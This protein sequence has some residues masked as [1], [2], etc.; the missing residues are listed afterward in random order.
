MAYSLVTYTSSGGQTYNVPFPYLEQAH[1]KVY[2]NGVATSAF[3]WSDAATIHL[4]N[5]PAVGA[6]VLIKRETPR[7]GMDKDFSAQP[8]L[9]G[10]DLDEALLQAYYIGLEALDNASHDVLQAYVDDAAAAQVAAEL[11][12]TNAEAARDLAIGAKDAAILARG[13]AEAARD[14]AVLAKI[15]AESYAESAGAGTYQEISSAPTTDANEV[16][17]YAKDVTGV[18]ELFIRKESNGTEVQVTN[19]AGLSGAGAH[20]ASH[21]AGGADSIKLDEL[22]APTDVTTLN[23]SVSAH[24]LCPK[25]PGNTTTFLRGDGTFAAA[26][27]SLEVA[28]QAETDAG[29]LD[30]KIVTPAKLY[31][32]PGVYRKN[33][34]INGD[35]MVW[36]RGTTFTASADGAFHADRWSHIEATDAVVTVSKSTNVPTDA[37]GIGRFAA[38]LQVDVT[39]ADTSIG[40]GQAHAIRYKVEGYDIRGLVGQVCTLS[41]WVYATKT[42]IYCVNLLCSGADHSYVKEYTI[43]SA[44]TWEKKTITFTLDASSGTWDF[45]N[46]VGLQIRWTLAAGSNYQTAT[47]GVWG[48]ALYA[49]ANQVNG[50]DSSDNYFLL[51]GVQL[52]KGSAATPFEYRHFAEELALCQRYFEKSYDMDDYPGESGWNQ[53][54]CVYLPCYSTTEAPGAA[55]KVAKRAAPTI[56]C[57][58]SVDGT[59]N[60]CY[61]DGANRDASAGYIGDMGFGYIAGFSYSGLVQYHWTASSEL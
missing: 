51:T 43:N 12:E 57:Y 46:G 58:S 60:K 9:K 35:M 56:T 20:A 1:V 24:G 29:A 31:A 49:T 15:A 61:S 17:L 38:S 37:Q 55:F 22:A 53:Q 54:G 25:L 32:T 44:N 34:V 8:R 21:K 28:T 3:T 16:K 52:E 6:T 50:L 40:S 39:T 47:D 26:A 27:C 30:T 5:A 2:I 59:V 18:T 10:E 36:Q 33:A 11:A 14:A 4:T 13:A 48:T 19:G 23:A 45:T 41:F 7:D 42:G